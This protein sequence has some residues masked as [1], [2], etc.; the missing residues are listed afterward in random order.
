MFRY[1]RVFTLTKGFQLED[2]IRRTFQPNNY[3]R[4]VPSLPEEHKDT[5]SDFIETISKYCKNDVQT[6]VKA[7]VQ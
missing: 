2:G 6:L 3:G 7:V 5:P 1:D 4:R